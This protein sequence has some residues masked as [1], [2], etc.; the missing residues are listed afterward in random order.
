M[1]KI[2][3]F[4]DGCQHR[5]C[6]GPHENRWNRLKIT[7]NMQCLTTKINIKGFSNILLTFYGQNLWFDDCSNWMLV[8]T[9]AMFVYC[10]LRSVYAWSMDLLDHVIIS[11]TCLSASFSSWSSVLQRETGN[12]MYFRVIIGFR[13][14]TRCSGKIYME[15]YCSNT[16]LIAKYIDSWWFVDSTQ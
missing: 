6:I 7:I 15:L 12:K 4:Q 8:D 16:N 10:R 11:A 13:V 5:K 1:T 3:T 2:S 14:I 9:F